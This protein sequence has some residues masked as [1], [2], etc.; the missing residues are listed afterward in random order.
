MTSSLDLESK[1]LD[2]TICANSHLCLSSFD[3]SPLDAT[4]PNNRKS[5]CHIAFSDHLM[6]GDLRNFFNSSFSFDFGFK[7]LLNQVNDDWIQQDVP[8]LIF[9][10]MS[11]HIKSCVDGHTSHV[12]KNTIGPSLQGLPIF[13]FSNDLHTDRKQIL[14]NHNFKH[15]ISDDPAGGNAGN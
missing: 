9:S 7:D 8:A 15:R 5:T 2:I 1:R 3:T 12:N 6:H 4:M 14:G 10:K 11:D 13:P